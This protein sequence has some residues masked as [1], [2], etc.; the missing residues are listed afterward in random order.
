[1]SKTQNSTTATKT[2]GGF[3]N[4]ARNACIRLV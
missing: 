1:M 2:Y 4:N 3:C